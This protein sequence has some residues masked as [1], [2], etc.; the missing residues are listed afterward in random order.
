MSSPTIL[1]VLQEHRRR[2]QQ[3]ATESTIDGVAMAFGPGLVTELAHLVYH[4]GEATIPVAEPVRS[5]PC[6]TFLT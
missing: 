2:L 3:R 6:G 5:E 4:V 1:F